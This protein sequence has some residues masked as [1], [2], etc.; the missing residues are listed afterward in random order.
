MIQISQHYLSG[1]HQKFKEFSKNQIVGRFRGHFLS[2]NT[3]E[4]Q[5]EKK[6]KECSSVLKTIHYADKLNV[7]N[8][9]Q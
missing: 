6:W 9:E 2:I 1:F 4:K 5:L 3:E 8:R 7:L